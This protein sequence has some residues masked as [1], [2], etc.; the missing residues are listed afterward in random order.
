MRSTAQVCKTHSM[1][2]VLSP[3]QQLSLQ[4]TADNLQPALQARIQTAFGAGAGAGL[5]QLGARELRTELPGSLAWF[6]RLGQLY[7]SGL[8]ALPDLEE[9]RERVSVPPPADA[10]AA[11]AASPPPMDGAE[12]LDAAL[13]ERLWSEIEAACRRQ[14]AAHTGTVEAWLH[15]QS[16][17][18]NR[19]GRVCLHLAENKRDP[20]RPFA[21]LATY[22]VRLSAAGQL[23]HQPLGRALK[24]SA[25]TGDRQQLITLLEPVQRAA[26][27]ST[28]IGE[29]VESRAIFSP[30]RWDARQAHRFLRDL[31][32]LEAAGLSIRVP[33]WWHTG[34]P[35][36]PRVSVSIGGREQT[37]V[38]LTAMLSF[39]IEVAVDGAPLSP[40]EIAALLEGHD[41]LVMLRGRWVEVDTESLAENLERWQEVA[42]AAVRDGISF[43]EGMRLLAGAPSD[44]LSTADDAADWSD[45]TAGPWL[46]QL[47]A[48]LRDPGQIGATTEPGEDFRA[49]LRPYQREGV[50]W[51]SLLTSLGLG[52]C[53]ADDMGL[54]KT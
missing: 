21:F 51:L 30:Q 39:S 8:C 26:K 49:T 2:L 22:A 4:T 48:Q 24:Q 29:L 18:W 3:Q 13:L 27:E 19:V 32:A 41:G 9:Q 45:V 17:V 40:E 37:S 52:A 47:L 28:L 36:R 50:R 15:A 43:A 35:P 11:L 7:M 5:L 44:L 31:P 12:Y 53:L 42:E 23:Q 1:K 14:L 20:S 54:G 46:Q 38:G 25:Q 10:L 6:R 16:P 34:R 33:A